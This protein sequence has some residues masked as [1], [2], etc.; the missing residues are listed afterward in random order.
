MPKLKHKTLVSVL[1]SEINALITSIENFSSSMISSLE[2]QE[3]NMEA[4]KLGLQEYANPEN[5]ILIQIGETLEKMIDDF[6]GSG[7]YWLSI[8]SLLDNIGEFSPEKRFYTATASTLHNRAIAKLQDQND[9]KTPPF[10]ED[11]EVGA[12]ILI[13]ATT[14]LQ[15]L[16]KIVSA[17]ANLM[18]LSEVINILSEIKKPQTSSSRAIQP[19]WENKTLEQLIPNI[20]TAFNGAR[21]V[22]KGLQQ[23]GVGITNTI[24]KAIDAITLKKQKIEKLKS[25]IIELKE[26]IEAAQKTAIYSGLIQPSS[27]G[28]PYLVSKMRN[29]EGLPPD[30]LNLNIY[31][32]GVGGG[33][34][35]SFL[36]SFLG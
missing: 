1:P 22:A 20:R 6:A 21:N 18:D 27:G 36:T 16:D 2:V 24:Q 3:V 25:H 8:S 11:T 34:A 19:S 31:L 12:L 33:P 28:I 4:M 14:T 23:T 17:F 35:F 5:M 32:L 30:E 29:V 9:P 15:E 26:C 13:G 10:S 7:V